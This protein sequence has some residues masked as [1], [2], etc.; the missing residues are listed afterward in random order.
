MVREFENPDRWDK[1]A[2]QYETTAHPF[3]A[4][5]AEAVLRDAFP[6]RR[7]VRLI[8]TAL[9]SLQAHSGEGGPQQFDFAM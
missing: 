6:L 3:T 1:I 9:F 5:F 2:Q 4:R 8:G 7:S